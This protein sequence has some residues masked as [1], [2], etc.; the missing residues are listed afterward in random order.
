MV[1]RTSVPVPF[2]NELQ[3]NLNHVII[4]WITFIVDIVQAEPA[5]CR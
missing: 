5:R 2:L 3:M 1:L 4:F